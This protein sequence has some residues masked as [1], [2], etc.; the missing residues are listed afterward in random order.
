MD[1]NAI[2]I[3]SISNEKVIKSNY[4]PINLDDGIT[5]YLVCS[6]RYLI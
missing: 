6:Q 3:Y 4:I 2:I 1:G 5:F